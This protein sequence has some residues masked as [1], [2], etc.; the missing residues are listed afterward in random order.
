M[1]SGKILRGKGK[2]SYVSLISGGLCLLDLIIYTIYGA[3]Y[4]Y[5]DIVAF[6]AL[7]LAGLCCIGYMLGTSGHTEWLNLLAVLLLS[8]SLCLIFLNSIYVWADRVN[9]ITMYG[10]RG[11]LAPVIT[12][13]AI[14]LVSLVAELV[15]C[16]CVRKEEK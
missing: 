8:L 16:F 2:M 13:L 11:T 5:F 12:I 6:L 15:T 7:L 10:S 1:T 3:V 14:N 9:N 4:D